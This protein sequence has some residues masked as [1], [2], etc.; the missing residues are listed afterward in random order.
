M[1]SVKGRPTKRTERYYALLAIAFGTAVE[2]ARQRFDQDPSE[3][4]PT[5]P[6]Q[7]AVSALNTAGVPIAPKTLSNYLAEA[8]RL[9]LFERRF[10]RYAAALPRNW[11]GGRPTKDAF[12]HAEPT[13]DHWYR[14]FGRSWEI[15][16][17]SEAA[18]ALELVA[19]ELAREAERARQLNLRERRWA[20]DERGR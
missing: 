13:S 11:A 4:L 19:R 7:I 10:G 20:R 6:R 8:E 14:R 16:K 18:D 15:M 12:Q 2:I 9:S 1:G 5:T 17:G 3:D